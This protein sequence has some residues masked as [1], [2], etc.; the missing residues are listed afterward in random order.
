MFTLGDWKLYPLSDGYFHLDGGQVFGVVPKALWSHHFEAD[1]MNRIPMFLRPLLIDCGDQ[2]VLIDCGIGE[3]YEEK[4]ARIYKITREKGQLLKSLEEA[5]FRPQDITHVI[6][7]H[8]HFDH[9]GYATYVDES[10]S[11][12]ITFPNAE[13]FVS[14]GEWEFAQNL[15]ERTRP[16]Y[17]LDWVD[18]LAASGRLRPV[19]EDGNILP[20]INYFRTPGHLPHHHSLL[21]QRQGELLV[22]WGDLIP[23]L[24]HLRPTW[25]SAI[26]THPLETLEWKKRL[27]KQARDEGWQYHYFY[28]EKKP[29]RTAEEVDRFL[30][31]PVESGDT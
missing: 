25:I 13:F 17:R 15:N 8:L 10:G 11:S 19:R 1:A 26:D 21:V 2:R 24:P 23:L 14:L 6:F 16:S 27:L 28:H 18:P 7:S 3:R 22:F 20:G 29:L 5:G 31:P 4:F 30:H 9:C 12:A